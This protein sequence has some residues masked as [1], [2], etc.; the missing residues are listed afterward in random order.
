VIV[1]TP[2]PVST[3]DALRGAKMFQRVGVPVL[4]IVENMSYFLC[5]HC[6]KPTPLFG[7][8][9]GKQLADELELPLLGEIPLVPM[10]REGG[11]GGTPIVVGDPASPAAKALTQVAERLMAFLPAP[12]RA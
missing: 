8:G 6:G 3:G 9:G 12:V 1:T 10:V 4:G 7:T 5:P 11:D 2:Q